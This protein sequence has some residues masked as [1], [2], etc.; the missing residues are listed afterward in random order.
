MIQNE[1]T[2]QE[3]FL[4]IENSYCIVPEDMHMRGLQP[5]K[6]VYLKDKSASR[7]M[8]FTTVCQCNCSVFSI[9]KKNLLENKQQLHYPSSLCRAI[10]PLYTRTYFTHFEHT[11]CKHA[12]YFYAHIECTFY[13]GYHSNY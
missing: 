7:S 12:F 6:P 5:L 1:S 10:I 2:T 9:L 11:L 13:S 8:G 3:L 4:K